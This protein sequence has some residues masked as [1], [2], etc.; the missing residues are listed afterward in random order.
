MAPFVQAQGTGHDRCLSHSG[1]ATEPEGCSPDRGIVPLAREAPSLDRKVTIRSREATL[2]RRRAP[3]PVRRRRIW[4]L[5]LHHQS[6]GLLSSQRNVS[7]NHSA[8]DITQRGTITVLR[9]SNISQTGTITSQRSADMSQGTPAPSLTGGAP[10]Q[11]K[12]RR[13]QR[14]APSPAFTSPPR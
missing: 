14:G 11:G 13:Y 4:P 12:A 6:E 3:S 9:D 5:R 10:A 2:L 1:S 8:A 7:I